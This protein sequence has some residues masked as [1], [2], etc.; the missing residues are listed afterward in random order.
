MRISRKKHKKYKGSLSTWRVT[1]KPGPVYVYKRH[2]FK[3]NIY[4]KQFCGFTKASRHRY[5]LCTWINRRNVWNKRGD[6]QNS[7]KLI[8]RECWIRLGRMGKN[9]I[10][11][12][13][14]VPSI[15]NSRV[16]NPAEHL[17]W[18]FYCENSKPVSIFPK[19][20]H[21]RCSLGS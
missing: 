4:L 14:R 12:K 17:W 8:N 3:K 9:G 15:R 11:K 7:P 13:Q 16:Y 6:W 19:R 10:I 2:A 5:R 18:S 21:R 20:H 1:S